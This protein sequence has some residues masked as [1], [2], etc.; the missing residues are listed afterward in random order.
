M[1][2]V[3][4]DRFLP[5]WLLIQSLWRSPCSLILLK[6][7]LIFSIDLADTVAFSVHSLIGLCY[8]AFCLRKHYTT[9]A[10]QLL[11]CFHPGHKDETQQNN[12]CPKANMLWLS[13][14]IKFPPLPVTPSFRAS[15]VRADFHS[16]NFTC[17][18]Q[19]FTMP[20][21]IVYFI[22]TAYEHVD[23]LIQRH[24]ITSKD[25]HT[26]TPISMYILFT[27][28]DKN[29]KQY[30]IRLSWSAMLL[31]L[32]PPKYWLILQLCLRL[33]GYVCFHL[34]QGLLRKKAG[35]SLWFLPFRRQGYIE[36]SSALC[37]LWNPGGRMI[38]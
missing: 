5:V 38:G 27:P 14:W 17:L 13:P 7:T 35:A 24:S 4:C 21:N 32:D 19:F 11:A 26:H 33:S 6:S 12:G 1:L 9:S 31:T 28:G 30:M 36:S 15:V 2:C 23:S 18:F 20:R 8:Q 25:T 16:I 29:S 3:I 10:F 37:L 34:Y 22:H